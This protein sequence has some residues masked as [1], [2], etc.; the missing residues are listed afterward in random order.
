[1]LAANQLFATLDTTLR[2]VHVPG[3]DTIV[4][5]DTVGFIRD[6]PHDLVA[7]FRATLSEAADADLLL[8]VI[9]ASAPDRDEQVAAVEGV[10]EEIGAAEVPQIRVLNKCD[11][12]GL[13]IGVERDPCGTITAVRTSALTGAGCA[14]LRDALAERFPLEPARSPTL[15]QTARTAR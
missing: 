12:A 14:A 10:L 7:A 6:L 15:S 5:S 3:A 2:R 8:H 1:V 11:L 13:P 9:D 4:L